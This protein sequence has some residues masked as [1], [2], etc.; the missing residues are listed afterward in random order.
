MWEEWHITV[1]MGR[2]DAS[3]HAADLGGLSSVRS[4]IWD[5]GNGGR[6]GRG[7]EEESG[8][9]GERG[10]VCVCGGGGGAVRVGY[11]RNRSLPLH[12]RHHAPRIHCWRSLL[13]PTASAWRPVPVQTCEGESQALWRVSEGYGQ[14][15]APGADESRGGPSRSRGRCGRSEPSHG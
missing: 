15:L 12:S 7:G 8:R 13:Q 3:N 6:G 4:Q 11:Q 9:G 5:R 1:Q 14:H 10:R 2:K